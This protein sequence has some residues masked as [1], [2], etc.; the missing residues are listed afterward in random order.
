MPLSWNEIRS[1]A[2]IFA[3]EWEDESSEKAE[4]QSF[5]N[6]FFNVFG[7]SRRRVASFEKKLKKL[8]NKQRYIDLI[9]KGEDEE[10][11]VDEGHL[12]FGWKRYEKKYRLTD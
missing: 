5:W 2:I 6:D 7:I 12:Y 8:G 4:S 3:K 1:R 9:W 11:E 10:S